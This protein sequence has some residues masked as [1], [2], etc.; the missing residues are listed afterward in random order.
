MLAD[1][2]EE[3]H[4]RGIRLM[5]AREIGQVRDILH[6]VDDRVLTNVYSTVQAAVDAAD[7]QR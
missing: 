6:V 1:L 2:T 4:D 7:T 3:L 5:I